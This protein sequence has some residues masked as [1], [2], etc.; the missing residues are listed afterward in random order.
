M[1]TTR[2]QQLKDGEELVT[3]GAEP[4]PDFHTDFDADPRETILVHRKG[5]LAAEEKPL[6]PG[7]ARVLG[8]GDL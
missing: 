8:R 5:A 4:Q 7:S 3:S 6:Q 2:V 1:T